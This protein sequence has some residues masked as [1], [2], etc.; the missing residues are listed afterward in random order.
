MTMMEL[1]KKLRVLS[2]ETF[3]LKHQIARVIGNLCEIE[4]QLSPKETARIIPF[5]RRGEGNGF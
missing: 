4:H 5:P 2:E 1:T 3:F